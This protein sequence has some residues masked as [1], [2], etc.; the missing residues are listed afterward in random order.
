[1]TSAPFPSAGAGAL[2]FGR[3]R[4]GLATATTSST[5]ATFTGTFLAATCQSFVND[6]ESASLPSRARLRKPDDL[7]RHLR[8]GLTVRVDLRVRHPIE[9][10]AVLLQLPHAPD[11]ILSH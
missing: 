3:R 10:L 5:S 2:V 8:H 4:L 7:I 11:G 6:N 1:M 9:R